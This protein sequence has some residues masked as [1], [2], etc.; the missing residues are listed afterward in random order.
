M[1]SSAE[2]TSTATWFSR[3]R[4]GSPGSP[5]WNSTNA[6]PSLDP[7][8]AVGRLGGVEPELDVLVSRPLRIG[9]DQ[10]DVVEVV[11][12][13]GRRLDE[14]HADAVSEVE[15]CARAVRKRRAGGLEIGDPQGDVLERAALA[16][17]FGLEERQLSVAR[18]RPDE[19]E[20]LGP[21]DDVHA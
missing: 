3:G 11:L 19:R 9:R 17:A 6:P 12:D 8:Q 1:C 4:S 13:L 20:P 2:S 5:S 18:V 14:S 15:V 10:R 7:R 21:I 16:R